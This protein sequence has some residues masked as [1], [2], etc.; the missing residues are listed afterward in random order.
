MYLQSRLERANGETRGGKGMSRMCY[1]C[2]Q[3]H[4]MCDVQMQIWAWYVVRPYF[5]PIIKTT[6][7]L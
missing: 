6:L 3:V 4:A 5:I 1:T 2:V 7:V